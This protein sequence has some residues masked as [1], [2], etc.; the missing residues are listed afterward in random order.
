VPAKFTLQPSGAFVS[1]RALIG[2]TLAGFLESPHTLIWN[3][4][5]LNAK[6]LPGWIM[7]GG[8]F[9]F[10]LWIWHAFKEPSHHDPIAPSSH[11]SNI[12]KKVG[13]IGSNLLPS[14]K[15]SVA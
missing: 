13:K 8:W 9:L 2:P 12:K 15:T 7:A 11:S 4:S 10:L 5:T 6:A 3:Y 14:V 1:A